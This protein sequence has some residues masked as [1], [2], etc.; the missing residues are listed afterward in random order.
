[1]LNK[2]IDDGHGYSS[3]LRPTYSPPHPS[4]ELL[5][6]CAVLMRGEDHK[7]HPIHSCLKLSQ[8]IPLRYYLHYEE[9]LS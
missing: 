1:M 4:H 7:Q 3:L 2:N 5:G 8:V 9:Y 6:L